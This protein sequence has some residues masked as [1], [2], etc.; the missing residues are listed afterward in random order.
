MDSRFILLFATAFVA[1]SSAHTAKPDNDALVGN[2]RGDSICVVRPSACANEKSLYH[3]KKIGDQPN[4][5]SMQGDKIVDGRPV[6]MGTADCIYAPD[7]RALTCELPSGSIHLTLRETR[8]EGTMHLSDGRL[9]R[10]ISL[11]KDGT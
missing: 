7:K 5:F 6:A 9:W 3:I 11:K 1:I 10:N 8:L 4:R 2:W